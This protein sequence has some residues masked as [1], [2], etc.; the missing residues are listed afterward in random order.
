MPPLYIY[1][2]LPSIGADLSYLFRSYPS[3]AKYSIIRHPCTSI[4]HQPNPGA[5]KLSYNHSHR[6][7]VLRHVQTAQDPIAIGHPASY[8]RR[9]HRAEPKGAQGVGRRRGHI[10]SAVLEGTDVLRKNY[11]AKIGRYVEIGNLRL[12]GLPLAVLKI[13]LSAQ[14]IEVEMP[15]IPRQRRRV[16]R[17]LGKIAQ[18]QRHFQN[19]VAVFVLV[20]IER[21]R[22]G[23]GDAQ[24]L[25]IP[26]VLDHYPGVG[27]MEAIEK[28]TQY[29]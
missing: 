5:D 14:T 24:T 7:E 22:N 26:I 21:A 10:H 16:R 15:H 17:Y 8:K 9:A 11:P 27:G 23:G 25:G 1:A 18:G 3:P 28:Y 6:A 13:G 4:N 12:A 29:I 20:V 2:A 19:P